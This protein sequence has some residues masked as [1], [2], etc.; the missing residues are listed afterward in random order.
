MQDNAHRILYCSFVGCDA[1]FDNGVHLLEHLHEHSEWNAPFFCWVCSTSFATVG[2]LTRHSKGTRH[3]SRLERRTQELRALEEVGQVSS[4]DDDDAG[5]LSDEELQLS[6]EARLAFME[7]MNERPLPSNLSVGDDLPQL[8]KSF[9]VWR[10]RH[11]VTREAMRDLLALCRLH[12]DNAPQL[13][14]NEHRLSVLQREC[15]P[16]LLVRE[17]EFPEAKVHSGFYS[18]NFY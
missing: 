4:L 12:S 9:M 1:Q 7:E 11:H 14:R 3:L 6:A 8:T 17:I 18:S 15:V 2:Q 16:Q 13:P 10:Q 5:I